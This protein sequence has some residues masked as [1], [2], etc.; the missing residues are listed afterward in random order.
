M[1]RLESQKYLQSLSMQMSATLAAYSPAIQVYLV[2]SDF[3][4]R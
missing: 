4:E 2:Q 3:T 1:R